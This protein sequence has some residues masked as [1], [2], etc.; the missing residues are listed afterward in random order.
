M[1]GKE[2][3]E[4]IIAGKEV[5]RMPF[6]VLD[7]GAWAETTTGLTYR[8][9]LSLEDAGASVIVEQFNKINADM[10]SSC[11]AFAGGHL[12]AIDCKLNIDVK[13]TTVNSHKSMEDLEEDIPK[14]DKS[15]IKDKLANNWIWQRLLHQTREIKKLVGEDKLIAACIAGPFTTAGMLVGVQDFMMLLV[16]EEMEDELN[17][18]LDYAEEACVLAYEELHEAGVDVAWFGEPVSSGAMISQD[19]FEEFAKEPIQRGYDRLKNTYKYIFMHMCGNSG[20]RVATIKDM[21]FDAFS[22]DA[23]VDLEQAGKDSDGKMVI[24]GNIGPSDPLKSG[25]PQEVEAAAKEAVA[26]IAAGNGR[27]ILCPGCDVPIGTS[28]ENILAMEKTAREKFPIK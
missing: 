26:K 24:I 21:G 2:R 9:F 3:I 19:M 1:N 7:A 4:A 20:S 13:N 8:E 15:Q 22:V 16:D 11:G 18:L 14:L 27:L 5:D 6:A 10:V 12:D 25:T 23:M 28:Y 17:H